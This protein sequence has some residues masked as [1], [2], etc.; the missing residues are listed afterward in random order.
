MNVSATGMTA[1]E[2]FYDNSRR[3]KTRLIISELQEQPRKALK[4]SGFLGELGEQ[5]IRNSLEEALQESSVS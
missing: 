1:L 3:K 2:N 4:H 5:N